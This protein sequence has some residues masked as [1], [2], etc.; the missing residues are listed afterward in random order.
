MACGLII[1]S[2]SD[3]RPNVIYKRLRTARP[4]AGIKGTVFI[5]A[6]FSKMGAERKKKK[7]H[8]QKSG[9]SGTF[10]SCLVSS[11]SQKLQTRFPFLM[12]AETP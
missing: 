10:F 9:I 11:S 3:Y 4:S 6:G 2:K 7:T 5:V 1:L 8:K 12:R